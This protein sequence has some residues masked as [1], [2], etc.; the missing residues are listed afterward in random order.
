MKDWRP[1]ALCVLYKLLSKVLANRLKKILHKCIADSQST[2]VPGRSILDN[3]LVV[4]ELVHYMKTKTKGNEK[5]V[6]LKLYISKEYDRNDW[7]YL[8]DVMYK[9]GFSGKWIQWIMMCVETVDYSVIMNKE[10]EDLS[11]QDAG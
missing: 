2:F 10:I 5:S 6:A 8:K 1:I 9:M 7:S 4:M 3:A 11:F